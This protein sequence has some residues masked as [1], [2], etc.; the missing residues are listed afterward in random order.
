MGQG[1]DFIPQKPFG[2]VAQ[3]LANS[4]SCGE[5][6]SPVEGRDQAQVREM[7]QTCDE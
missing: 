5:R 7:E 4:R 6:E 3:E 1:M 2:E